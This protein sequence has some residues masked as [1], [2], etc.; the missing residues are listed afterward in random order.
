VDERETAEATPA[1]T[2]GGEPVP[3]NGLH[4]AKVRELFDGMAGAYDDLRDLWYGYL[5]DRLH[6]FLERRYAARAEGMRVLDVGCGTGQQALPFAGW[7]A[8][9]AALDL[10]VEPLRVA[11][12]KAQRAGLPLGLLQGSAMELPLPSGWA[13][14]VVSCGSVISFV[15]DYDAALAEMRRVLRPGG[16]LAIEFEHRW[17]PDLLWP[18]VD[19]LCGGRLGYGQPLRRTL[20]NLV[21][22]ADAPVEIEYPFV[23]PDG[24]KVVF[25][26]WLFG[27]AAI[28]RVLARNG[29]EPLE[30]HAIHSL[31]NLLPSTLLNDPRPRPWVERAFALLARAEDRLRHLPPLDRVGNSL[32][33]IARRR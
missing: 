2:R 32:L 28:D 4:Q 21:A 30:R 31:T 17:S 1:A 14:L 8:Q 3:F 12:C 22:R 23:R 19:R 26:L 25:N 29:F 7:G 27:G 6:L 15:P 18:L 13:D 10:A 16:E 11:R 20:R 5:F 24:V 9:V 33:V